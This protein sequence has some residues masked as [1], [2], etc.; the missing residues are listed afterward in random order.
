MIKTWSCPFAHFGPN[1]KIISL[2]SFNLCSLLSG[3]LC[4]IP[5]I[6]PRISTPWLGWSLIMW[7]VRLK[8]VF[9]QTVFSF[10]QN[11]LEHLKKERT[12]SSL[13]MSKYNCQFL[14]SWFPFFDCM[15][16]SRQNPCIKVSGMPLINI[17]IR[18]WSKSPK[19]SKWIFQIRVRCCQ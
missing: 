11:K 3:E 18:H 7:N 1:F 2:N 13:I 12:C 8:N 6:P 19:H 15:N 17:R 14:L 4:A 9:L 10:K 5:N 16:F